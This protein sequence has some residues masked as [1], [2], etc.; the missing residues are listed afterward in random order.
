MSSFNQARK[1]IALINNDIGSRSCIPYFLNKT[2]SSFIDHQSV[3]NACQPYSIS[4]GVANVHICAAAHH[5]TIASSCISRSHS[6]NMNL[7]DIVPSLKINCV[8]GWS[9]SSG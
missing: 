4:A 5:Y 1:I 3:Y 9:S 2:N 7:G 8:R 6:L